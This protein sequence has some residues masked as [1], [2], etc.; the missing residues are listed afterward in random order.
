MSEP[1]PN[2]QPE[3]RLEARLIQAA[4]AFPY[5]PAPDVTYAVSRRLAARPLERMRRGLV[6]AGV[7]LVLILAMVF[8]VPPVRAAVLEW[9]RLG[10]VRIFFVQPTPSPMPTTSPRAT[11]V[12]PTAGLQASLPAIFP[13]DEPAPTPLRSV[14]DLSGETTLD[15][16]Q[17]R[18]G[19]T[20]TL[21]TYPPDLGQP[22]H[23]FYQPADWVVAVLVW[24]DPADPHKARLVL[25]ETNAEAIIFQK[26]GVESAVN[27]LVNGQNALW[28]EGPYMLLTNNGDMAQARLVQNSHTLI[29]TEGK[30]TY[31]LE[32]TDPLDTAIRIA[33]SI[34]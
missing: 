9:L 7:T 10:A 19:F 22:D 34:R 28:V 26:M 5:P 12:A 25:S 6:L 14:L 2:L 32:T 17:A 33:E 15:K 29:W 18:N 31:R 24:M 4:G 8:G 13:T 16:I 21:P 30:M 20:V 27:T 23:V 1:A 3:D 11:L